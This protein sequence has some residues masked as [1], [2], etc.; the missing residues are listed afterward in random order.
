MFNRAAFQ[1]VLSLLI[2]SSC[3]RK[4]NEEIIGNVKYDYPSNW[5][6]MK[7]NSID[8]KTIIYKTPNSDSIIAEY[9]KHNNEF[10]ESKI[11]VGNDSIFNFIKSSNPASEV[12][13]AF[14][15][16]L[17]IIKVSF[18]ITTITMIQLIII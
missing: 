15:E 1:L 2:F 13:L 16:E 10:D 11:I 5:K 8:S 3:N 12:I 9:G 17:I 6:K 4:K 7:N 14:N 18:W